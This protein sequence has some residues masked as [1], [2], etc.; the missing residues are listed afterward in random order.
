MLKALALV[1]LL[2]FAGCAN[3]VWVKQGSNA[4]D[5]QADTYACERDSRQSGGF[6]GGLAGA[7][8]VQEYFNR[9]MTAKGWQQQNRESAQAQAATS[10]Q[11]GQASVE[12][13]RNCMMNIRMETVFSSIQHKFSDPNISRFNF[14]QMTD[15]NIPTPVEASLYSQYYQRFVECRASYLRSAQPYISAAKMQVLRGGTTEADSLVAEL[16]RRKLTWGEFAT[17]ANQAAEQLDQQY[18]QTR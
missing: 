10:Q 4:Q 1:S 9:C 12:Q 8:A 6:G 13:R 7:I 16:V 2:F 14:S 5:Y 15:A 11:A 3:N 18:R 17:R